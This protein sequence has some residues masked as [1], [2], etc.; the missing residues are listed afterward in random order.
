MTWVSYWNHTS[1]Y[2]Q[3]ENQPSSSIVIPCIIGLKRK[4]LQM[5]QRNSS[6]LVNFFLA[7]VEKRMTQ[8]LGLT[9]FLEN[10]TYVIASIIDPRIKLCWAPENTACIHQR[11]T[12]QQGAHHCTKRWASLHHK[13]LNLLRNADTSRNQLN[14]S[15]LTSSKLMRAPPLQLTLK[16]TIVSHIQ[17]WRNLVI[18]W[19]SGSP[20]TWSGQVWH[21]C[22][23]WAPQPYHRL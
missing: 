2:T 17:P 4:L 23:P 1:V 7:S 21:S 22:S 16:L 10:D 14:P 5:Q 3:L 6:V 9:Q 15:C 8:F 19:G 12:C 13:Q 20:N 11:H 18:R